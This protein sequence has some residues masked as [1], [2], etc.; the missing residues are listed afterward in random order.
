MEQHK[1][2]SW[3]MRVGNPLDKLDGLSDELA[4]LEMVQSSWV[5]LTDSEQTRGY[6][7]ASAPNHRAETDKP[8]TRLT[9]SEV[10]HLVQSVNHRERG[11]LPTV[12]VNPA[13]L[14][15]WADDLLAAS[16]FEH[17]RQTAWEDRNQS[18]EAEGFRHHLSPIV[19]P[20]RVAYRGQA[21]FSQRNASYDKPERV[22][23]VDLVG[24]VVP[25]ERI[26]AAEVVIADDG[27]AV[28]RYRT[29][30]HGRR[31]EAL[32]VPSGTFTGHTFLASEAKRTTYGK[33]ERAHARKAR[34]AVAGAGTRGKAVSP[35]ALADR[36]LR[37]RWADTPD[38]IKAQAD[39][40]VAVLTDTVPGTVLELST[41]DQVTTRDACTV[42][43]S[44]GATY[45]AVQFARRA[46]L[47]GVAID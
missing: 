30:R 46:A 17:S 8:R 2:Y 40:I 44:S 13:L 33:A 6:R 38:D 27:T 4:G 9:Q 24:D 1:Q 20:D 47:A 23:V 25:C 18:L 45:S 36:S 21:R 32:S 37:Q 19:A 41:G 26:L 14:E 16:G 15:R 34:K 7:A 43:L 35:W 29:H 31:T 3:S 28:T 11:T 10:S 22:F 42:V 12:D 5:Y 39:L